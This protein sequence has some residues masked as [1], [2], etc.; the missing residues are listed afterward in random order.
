MD[1][2]SNGAVMKSPNPKS[3]IQNPKSKR[4]VW[5]LGVLVGITLLLFGAALHAATNPPPLPLRTVVRTN[6]VAA[7]QRKTGTTN[8]LASK[9]P[10]GA[11][12]NAMPAAQPL[13][14]RIK[15]QTIDSF[16]RFQRAG[17]FFPVII[18][19]PVCLVLAVV[20]FR[21]FFKAKSS[22]A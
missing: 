21:R 17:A 20:F 9:Q 1:K 18:G 22:S 7:P 13:L 19:V 6:A 14:T 4:G 3:K 10:A 12:T 2:W 15:S 11:R 8:A 5:N 16:H